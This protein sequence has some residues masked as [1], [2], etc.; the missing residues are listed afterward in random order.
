M[1]DRRST[2]VHRDVNIS[3]SVMQR[4]LA[5]EKRKA[6]GADCLLV[7]EVFFTHQGE[8]P[9]S[10]YPATFLRLAGCN[11]GSKTDEVGCAGCDTMFA[12]SAARV[13]TVS[14]VAQEIWSHSRPADVLPH[15]P[16]FLVIT[17]GEPLLQADSLKALFSELVRDRPQAQ[18]HVQLETNGDRLLDSLEMADCAGMGIAISI[19]VSPKFTGRMLHLPELALLRRLEESH[20]VDVS[21]R[22]VISADPTSPYHHVPAEL[23][24]LV[25][26]WSAQPGRIWDATRPLLWLSPMATHD[27]GGMTAL[28][29]RAIERCVALASLHSDH[30]IG[31]SVQIHR[32][33][34]VR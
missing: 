19:V 11:R 27:Q 24:A 12:Y 8:A 21:F 20:M 2:V 5:E 32:I 13:M 29:T 3:A 18:W 22:L 10:G 28:D 23:L 1:L 30:H 4:R 17:G 16:R 14:N 31:L 9:Y 15:V 6:G 33:F 34:N 25:R 26:T 7:T